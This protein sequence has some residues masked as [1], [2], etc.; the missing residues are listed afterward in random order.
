MATKE[1]ITKIQQRIEELNKER[2]ELY[3]S[4]TDESNVVHLD[5]DSI[6]SSRRIE[7]ELKLLRQSL[8]ELYETYSEEQRLEYGYTVYGYIVNGEGNRELRSKI[9]DSKL[10]EKFIKEFDLMNAIEPPKMED[11]ENFVME[12]TTHH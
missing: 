4:K 10:R 12:N 9:L 5:V 3:D 1:Q 7:S 2:K 6:I 11:I 8:V